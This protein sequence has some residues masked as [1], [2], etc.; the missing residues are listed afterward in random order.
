MHT[1]VLY[2]LTT[3]YNTLGVNF[4]CPLHQNDCIIFQR[5]DAIWAKN[6]MREARQ[7]I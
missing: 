3:V 6:K 2:Y 4:N 1:T 7:M 5:S